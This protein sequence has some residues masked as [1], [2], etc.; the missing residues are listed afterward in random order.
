[1]GYHINRKI[2]RYEI[3]EKAFKEV[4]TDDSFFDPFKNA[5]GEYYI[6]W[7]DK[8]KEDNV[9][10]VSDNGN[11]VGFL[12]LKTESE[13]EDFIGISPAFKLI[14]RL[15][16]SSLRTLAEYPGLGSFLMRF[17]FMEA[18]A[19]EV[20]EIYG[21]VPIDLPEKERVDRFL[22]KWG[23]AK[24]GEKRSRGL[25]ETVYVYDMRDKSY[26]ANLFTFE[27]ENPKNT[28]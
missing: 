16:I 18:E 26:L 3:A 10:T 19:N 9:Y 17:I 5:Y 24:Q 20:E 13:L 14:K 15:K 22:T 25:I 8:K 21:T 4:D 11:L 12:K 27:A 28:Q 1:M 23:Y 6:E 7:L 2:G